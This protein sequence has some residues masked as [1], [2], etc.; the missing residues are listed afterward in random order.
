MAPSTEG[1]GQDRNSLSR[2]FRPT[3]LAVLIIFKQPGAK[4]GIRYSSINKEQ[5]PNLSLE[6]ILGG[7]QGRLWSAARTQYAHVVVIVTS[8]REDQV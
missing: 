6:I 8:Q 7:V 4:N 3:G 5:R 1:Y 2:R